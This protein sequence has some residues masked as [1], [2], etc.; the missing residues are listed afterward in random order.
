MLSNYWAATTRA[1]ITAGEFSGTVLKKHTR[2]CLESALA[3]WLDSGAGM[4]N[5]I[6]TLSKYR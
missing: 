5:H 2:H 1:L 3:V 4:A 6:A